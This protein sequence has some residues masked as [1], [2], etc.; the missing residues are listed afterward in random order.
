MSVIISVIICTY[1]RAYLLSQCLDSLSNQ[2]LEKHFFEVL[3]INNNSTD[4]TQ[5]IAEFISKKEPNFRVI[6]ETS[7]GLSHAR[8]RGWNE[9]QGLYVGYLDDDCKVPPEWLQIAQSCITTQAPDMFGGPYYACYN[10]QKPKWFKDEYGSHVSGSEPR[11]LSFGEYLDGG[12]FFIKR[13][14]IRD[15][16]GFKTHLGMTGNSLGYGEE[17][18]LQIRT[19][20][21]YPESIIMYYPQLFVYHLVRKEKM[22]FKSILNQNFQSGRYSARILIENSSPKNMAGQIFGNIMYGA[23]LI[24]IFPIRLLCRNTSQYPYI[25]NYVY[26]K[27]CRIVSIV[28]FLYEILFFR[29]KKRAQK[30][31]GT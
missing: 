27:G 22:I 28:G 31:Q 14:L 23:A 13:T 2:T 9:A 1:N 11:E 21:T 7:Q 10:S 3:I 4:N 16:T 20:H 19:R 15:L 12:N 30:T 26:E 29:P 6:L 5:E 18:E 17:T 8:N 24:A 25:Q